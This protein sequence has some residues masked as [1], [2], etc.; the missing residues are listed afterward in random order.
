MALQ[1]EERERQE[2]QQQCEQM[3][4]K[5]DD[6]ECEVLRSKHK[7]EDNTC[8]E[9]RAKHKLDN[10]PDIALPEKHLEWIPR[11]CLNNDGSNGPSY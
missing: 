9:R 3:R 10:D 5:Y 1:Q 8:E 11:I 2:L 4:A 6:D 7:L